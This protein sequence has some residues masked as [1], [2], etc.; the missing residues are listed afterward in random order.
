MSTRNLPR[1]APRPKAEPE[2]TRWA[3]VTQASPL[4]IRIDGENVALPFTPESMVAGLALNDRVRVS[5]VTN[6]DPTFTGARVIVAEKAGGSGLVIPD[7]TITSAMILDATIAT[8]DIA[9]DAVT[10]AKM[11]NMAATTF[12][13]RFNASTGDPQDIS[14]SD[15]RSMLGIG[16]WVDWSASFTFTA[17]GGGLV[18][19]AGTT[20]YAE[21]QM[22]N[23]QTCTYQWEVIIGSGF[24]A[25]SGSW[26]FGLPFAPDR[27]GH[28]GNCLVVD[29]SPFAIYNGSL[30]TF[31]TSDCELYRSVDSGPT[32]APLGATSLTWAAG[33]MIRGWVTYK[34]A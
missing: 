8:G 32:S 2:V 33:D 23:P 25:G 18:K 5:F 27:P 20:Y 7:G 12:K 34:I 26:R 14:M 11:A 28:M 31:S 1:L 24:N 22:L 15:A 17:S 30:S 4:R 10:N 13:G 6:S 19:G 3:T 29:G 21:Y 9:N 16:S